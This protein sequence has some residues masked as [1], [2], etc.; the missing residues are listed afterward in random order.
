ML[1]AD[2]ASANPWI[3]LV[4]YFLDWGLLCV[5]FGIGWLIWAGLLTGT[6]QTPAKKLLK[7]RVIG[8]EDLMPVG[9]ARMFWVRGIIVDLIVIVVAMVTVGIIL[10]MP[11][12]DKRNQNLW[13]KISRTYVVRDPHD[14]WHF[15]PVRRQPST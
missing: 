5:T 9:F 1:P 7:L 11:F 3:R 10:L 8:S 6:G 2:V 4:S 15:K 12:W 13:D 14:A